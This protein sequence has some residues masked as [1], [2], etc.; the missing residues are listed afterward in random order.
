VPSQT[1]AGIGA[2]I[3]VLCLAVDFLIVAVD[4]PSRWTQAVVNALRS[5]VAGLVFLTTLTLVFTLQNYWQLRKI[6]RFWAMLCAFL[7]I[8]AISIFF[9]SSVGGIRYLLLN[10]AAGSE[11]GIF[12]LVLYRVFGAGPKR[13]RK[14]LPI[15][16]DSSP[17]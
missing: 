4:G 7:V 16:E 5:R 1:R 12:A 11:F 13:Q 9:R 15:P 17:A 3:V 14:K 8:F 2:A 10:I 6:P